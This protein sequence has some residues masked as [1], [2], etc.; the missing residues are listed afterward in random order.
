[1]PMNFWT[2]VILGVVGVYV[3]HH[4][5]TPLPGPNSAMKRGA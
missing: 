3:F 1:M 5:V 2:G 4:Y